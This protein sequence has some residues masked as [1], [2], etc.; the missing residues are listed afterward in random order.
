MPD[1]GGDLSQLDFQD[2]YYYVRASDKQERDWEDVPVVGGS[3][4][5]NL[6]DLMAAWTNDRWVSTLHRVKAPEAA[7]GDR[8]SIAF[9]H[10]PAYDARI[11]CI[12]TCTSPDDP[13]HHE[14]T[15]SGEWIVS[16]FEKTLN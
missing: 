14:P 10:Q 6:G 15:T 7:T 3:F 5:I 13:P 12:P 11:E 2:I 16:M 4:V 9:F 1:W 8:M